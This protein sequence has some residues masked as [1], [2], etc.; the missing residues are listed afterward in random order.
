MSSCNVCTRIYTIPIPPSKGIPTSAN[1]QEFYTFARIQGLS[2]K[3][4]KL[5][6]V[7]NEVN[8]PAPGEEFEL[9]LL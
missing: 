1:L 9:C 3:R 2:L 7:V 4:D 5:Q 8:P 6:R